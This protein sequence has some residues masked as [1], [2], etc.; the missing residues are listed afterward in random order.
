MD[1]LAGRYREAGK[2]AVAGGDAV[3]VVDHDGL[4][5]SA[6]KISESDYAVGG[7]DHWM[8]V[9]AADIH[10]AMKCA[11]SVERIDAFPETSRHL[12]FNRPQVGRRVGAVPVRRG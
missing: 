7:C 6:H 8:A 5:V 10:A 9:I 3:A 11:F 2:G 12:A 1:V 4:A